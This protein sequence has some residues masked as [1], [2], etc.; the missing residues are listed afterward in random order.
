VRPSKEYI[1]LWKT[2]NGLIIPPSNI[3]LFLTLH[4]KIHA[5]YAKQLGVKKQQPN[6][7]LKKREKEL[8]FYQK[9]QCLA[10]KR[11]K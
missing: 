9:I 8:S 2:W 4:I 6:Q 10:K 1:I 11:Y 5:M 7:Y 3:N